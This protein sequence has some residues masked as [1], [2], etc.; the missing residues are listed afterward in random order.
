MP[1][2][3]L[4]AR[5]EPVD[6][7]AVIIK[8]KLAQAPMDI[9]VARRKTFIDSKEEKPARRPL[10]PET[11]EGTLDNDVSVTNAA[12]YRVI[13]PTDA[14]AAESVKQVPSTPIAASDFEIEGGVSAKPAPGNDGPVPNLPVRSKK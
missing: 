6:F 10:M 9:E 5:G 7:D 13:V 8:Q 1:R 4:S 11:T 14:E 12:T 2:I 3:Y